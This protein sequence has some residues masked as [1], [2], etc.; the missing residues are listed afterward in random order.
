MPVILFFL[1]ACVYHRITHMDEEDLKWVTNRYVGETMYF[2]SQ[3]GIIDSV[4]INEIC[5]H[6]SLDPINW[7]YLNTNQKEYIATAD[8]RYSLNCN[9]GG[10]LHIEKKSIDE[11]IFFSS[12]LINGWLYDVPMM[13]TT[14]RID[15]INMNDIMFF[16]NR[17]SETIIQCGTNPII[18]Y[19]W[20][21]KYGLVE[22]T[23]KDGTT[24]TRIGID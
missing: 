6:N 22:Y 2:K 14:R 12:I 17:K 18:N 3:N 20:S 7:G 23:F 24:F 21:K 19:S 4:M 13:L 9:D 1:Y 8:V 15:D 5:I 10:V 16:D 11:P